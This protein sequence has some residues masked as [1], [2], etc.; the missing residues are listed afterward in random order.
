M[1]IGLL[2]Y[3]V[4]FP[5]RILFWAVKKSSWPNDEAL[6][7]RQDILSTF[8]FV[9]LPF[10]QLAILS[11]CHFVNLPF[12]QLAILSTWHFVNLPFWQ[13]TILS[14]CHF[15]NLP[16][17]QLAILTTCHLS[18][19]HFVQYMTLR[20]RVNVIKLFWC[21]FTNSFLKALSFHN[22]EK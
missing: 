7:W 8:H 18:T 6:F 22:T 15:V 2:S 17:C 1:Y 11:I 3:K 9:N 14:T 10:C 16:F 19:C 20:P 21:K 5:S 4:P 12:C 13:L